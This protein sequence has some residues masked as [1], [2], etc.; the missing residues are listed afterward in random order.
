MSV[1]IVT[2]VFT[3][4]GQNPFVALK[5]SSGQS[6]SLYDWSL[7]GNLLLNVLQEFIVG[8]SRLRPIFD[9]VLEESSFSRGVVPAGGKKKANKD[10]RVR[11]IAALGFSSSSNI[12]YFKKGDK[13]LLLTQELCLNK[14]VKI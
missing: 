7:L 3:L 8:R 10:E 9:Q 4:R 13:L 1:I 12:L 11:G 14:S 5:D 6:S 2:L